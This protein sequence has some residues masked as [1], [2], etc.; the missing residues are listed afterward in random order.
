[1]TTSPAVGLIVKAGAPPIV[2]F[3]LN[4]TFIVNQYFINLMFL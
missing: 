3:I 1:M 2:V 4:P